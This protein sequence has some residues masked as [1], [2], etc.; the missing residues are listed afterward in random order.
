[1][2][3]DENAQTEQ[4]LSLEPILSL[5]QPSCLFK[6]PFH[7]FVLSVS[8][9]LYVVVVIDVSVLEVVL[10]VKYFVTFDVEFSVK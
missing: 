4:Q 5:L 6:S 8:L 10:L 9:V 2:F 1:M 7:V 3:L